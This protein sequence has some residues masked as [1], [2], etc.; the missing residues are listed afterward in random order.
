MVLDFFKR[1]FINFSQTYSSF[2]N[3]M[4]CS[5]YNHI[6]L[7]TS[8]DSRKIYIFSIIF[9][10]LNKF[11]CRTHSFFEHSSLR[12]ALKIADCIHFFTFIIIGSDTIGVP[13][14]IS[15][16]Y[17]FF[18]LHDTTF[19]IHVGDLYNFYRHIYHF[20][21]YTFILKI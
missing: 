15:T 5:I 10:C 4:R 13:R 18:A 11:I 7:I 1:L 9:L 3:S 8:R 12:I 19:N 16:L 17:H 21:I 2:Y 14:L 6:A 20:H